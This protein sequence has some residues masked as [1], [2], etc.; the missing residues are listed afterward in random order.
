MRISTTCL[1]ILLVAVA[2]PACSGS[3]ASVTDSNVIST[4]Q[5]SI[6]VA[7]FEPQPLFAPLFEE[8]RSFEYEGET[9]NVMWDDEHPDADEYGNVRT[10]EAVTMSCTVSSVTRLP[11]YAFTEVDCDGMAG[12]FEVGGIW[13]VDAAGIRAIY[14]IPTSADEYAALAAEIPVFMAADPVD[15]NEGSETESEGETLTIAQNTEGDWCRSW[16]YW[17]GDEAGG[18][19]CFSATRGITHVADWW[20][21]GAESTTDLILVD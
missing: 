5:P 15:L 9:E 19:V 17:G 10:S 13:A 3:S 16:S 7:L 1:I 2:V 4:S 21:G 11:E 8:G 6:S 18:E 14:S 20:A 12:N